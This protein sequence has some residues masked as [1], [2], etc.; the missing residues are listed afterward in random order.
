MSASGTFTSGLVNFFEERVSLRVGALP[1][2]FGKDI[3]VSV[4]VNL[5]TRSHGAHCRQT[6]LNTKHNV[7]IAPLALLSH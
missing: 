3:W 4:L 7:L 6:P 1:L 5:C 2:T